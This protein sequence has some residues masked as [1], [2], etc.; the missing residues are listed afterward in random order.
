[1]TMISQPKEVSD[2]ISRNIR[3]VDTASN[4]L[5]A[6]LGKVNDVSSHE[7]KTALRANS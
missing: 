2:L 7:T 6:N 3:T 4:W 5:I 1:M